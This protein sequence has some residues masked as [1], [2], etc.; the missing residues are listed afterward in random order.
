MSDITS[1]SCAPGLVTEFRIKQNGGK[2]EAEVMSPIL[3]VLLS[4]SRTNQDYQLPVDSLV[5]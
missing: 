2:T 4:V 3:G 5:L 1:A